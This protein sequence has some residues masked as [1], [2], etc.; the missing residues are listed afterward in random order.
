MNGKPTL[1]LSDP[2]MVRELF[3][4]GDVIR[5][6]GLR[7]PEGIT[8]RDNIRYGADPDWNLLDIYY[9]TGTERPLPT[10]ISIHGGGW[11]YGDKDRYQFY[12]MDLALRGFAVVNF[13]Y[14]LAPEHIFPAA[15]EDINT[16]F[17]WIAEHA[18]EYFIDL[19]ELFLMGDSAG[20]SLAS[21]YM[22]ILTDE[23]YRNLFPF[24]VPCDRIRICGAALNCGVYDTLS[25]SQSPTAGTLL[26]YLNGQPEIYAEQMNLYSH[27]T[28]SYPP[29]FVMTSEC[30]MLKEL[31]LPFC[32]FL[33]ERGVAS[34]YHLFGAKNR[35]DLGHVFH[36]NIRLPE[37][38]EVN[39]LECGFFT[40][41]LP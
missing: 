2:W 41:L 37:A 21:Q 15:H 10:I 14:R 9:P 35:P 28:S 17:C 20:A 36:L 32:D 24:R 13:S 3:G 27:I 39:D 22:A 40:S 33:R 6:D 7:A 11:V 26:C 30:D 25:Y 23:S 31:A 18:A 38:K 5:D 12:C 4:K 29:C 34:E 19:S 1:D 8:R 16:V